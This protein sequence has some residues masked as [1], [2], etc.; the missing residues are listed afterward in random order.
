[1]TELSDIWEEPRKFWGNPHLPEP[2]VV[3]DPNDFKGTRV[4]G[5]L[6]SEL[7]F[8]C[9]D[10]KQVYVSMPSIDRLLQPRNEEERNRF[11]E[12]LTFHGVGHYSLIPFDLRGQ[13]ILTYNATQGLA[14]TGDEKKT[15]HAETLVNIFADVVLNTYLLENGVDDIGDI[16]VRLGERK[17]PLLQRIFRPQNNEGWDVYMRTLEHLWGKDGMVVGRLGGGAETASQEL[18]EIFADSKYSASRWPE[19]MREFARRMGPFM[20]E[21]RSNKNMRRFENGSSGELNNIRHGC[22]GK[23][24]KEYRRVME[25]S[26]RGEATKEKDKEKG[27]AR[28]VQVVTGSG[29][30]DV[31]KANVWFYRALGSQYAVQFTAVQANNQDSHP[32]S[33]AR[34]NPD[35]PISDLDIQYSASTQGRVIP[36]VSSYQ[37]AREQETGLK[38]GEFIPDLYI[39]LDSSGSMVDP[40]KSVAPAVVGS[41]AASECAFNKGASVAAC[42]FSSDGREIVVRETRDRDQIGEALVSYIGGCTNLP[43][44]G[45]I[46]MLRRKH[47]PKHVLLISDSHIH[48][49]EQAL[50]YLRG[51]MQSNP[52][53]TGS[54]FLVGAGRNDVTEELEKIGFCVFEIGD[55]YDLLNPILGRAQQVYGGGGI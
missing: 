11:A 41:F 53:N 52:Q 13:I 21:R 20:S 42:N 33:P 47:N 4:H 17:Q 23:E 25:Q 19:Q 10:D 2:I 18:A 3:N 12:L 37:W 1:M 40:T 49:F 31:K 28:Y 27:R 22:S 5:A 51:L 45:L 16:Y 43:T 39:V 48:N 24:Q 8:L 36:G 46:R 29:L 55:K 30:G 15:G 38:Q 26:L 6:K 35:D 34:W 9:L 32:Q 7:E 44:T 54:L 50:P 14:Q